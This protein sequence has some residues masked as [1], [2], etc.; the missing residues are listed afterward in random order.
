MS[1]CLAHVRFTPADEQRAYSE[2]R[3]E[4]TASTDDELQRAY[5]EAQRDGLNHMFGH[6]ARKFGN[7]VADEL[8][9]RGVTQIPNLFG[10]IEVQRWTY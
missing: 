3:A 9:S 7:L 6:N 10:P 2:T 5:L 1:I 4:L 8:L